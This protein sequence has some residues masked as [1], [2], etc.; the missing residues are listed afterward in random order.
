VAKRA[1]HARRDAAQLIA[2][3]ASLKPY[4]PRNP[5]PPSFTSPRIP[6]PKKSKIVEAKPD[7]QTMVMIG[8]EPYATKAEAKAARKASAECKKKED[9]N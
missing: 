3:V 7:G 5:A 2:P 4:E 6:R 1:G 8:A 9:A